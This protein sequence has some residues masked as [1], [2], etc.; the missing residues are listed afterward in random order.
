MFPSA[1]ALDL[2][3][4]SYADQIP[5]TLDLATWASEYYH[6]ALASMVPTSAVTGVWTPPNSFA[7]P[8]RAI[9]GESTSQTVDGLPPNG[10]CG[11]AHPPCFEA[12]GVP[13]WP[14]ALQTIVRAREM[15][16]NNVDGADAA[17]ELSSL[18]GV[19]ATDQNASVNYL[20]N[21]GGSLT[22]PFSYTLGLLNDLHREYPSRF[23][24]AAGDEYVRYFSAIAQSDGTYTYWYNSLRPGSK[25]MAGTTTRTSF[26]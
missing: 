23:I 18:L 19:F 1:G 6:G 2:P 12:N 8:F 16:G 20:A 11:G 17:I 15:A 26:G 4:S 5:A 22:T 10:F 13:Q 7:Y 25:A 21:G 14:I 9:Y 3:G 24:K